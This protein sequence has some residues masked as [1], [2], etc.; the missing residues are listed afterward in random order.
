MGPSP[1]AASVGGLARSSKRPRFP[2]FLVTA[3]RTEE[4]AESDVQGLEILLG[5]YVQCSRENAGMPVFEKTNATPK[6]GFA[7]GAAPRPCFLYYWGAEDGEELEGWWFGEEVGGAEVLC[8][9]DKKNFPPPVTGWIVPGDPGQPIRCLRV[10]SLGADVESEASVAERTRPRPPSGPPPSGPPPSTSTS[11]SPPAQQSPREVVSSPLVQPLRPPMRVPRPRSALPPP[12]RV[13]G[14]HPLQPP[15]P[16]QQPPQPHPPGAVP[17][18]QQWPS[19]PVQQRPPQQRPP[20]LVQQPRPGLP[21][22]AVAPGAAWPRPV[23]AQPRSPSAGTAATSFAAPVAAFAS[24]FSAAETKATGGQGGFEVHQV[25]IFEEGPLG[26]RL[27]SG[28]PPVYVVEVKAGS[29]AARRGLKPGFEILSINGVPLTTVREVASGMEDLQRRPLRLLVRGPPATAFVLSGTGSYL[30][31]AAPAAPAPAT[32]PGRPMAAPPGPAAP[33]TP[34]A[35]LAAAAAA[36][37]QQRLVPPA[38]AA[39]PAAANPPAAK[40]KPQVVAFQPPVPLAKPPPGHQQPWRQRDGLAQPP[41]PPESAPQRVAVLAL[42]L[43]EDEAECWERLMGKVQEEKEQE[44]DR[45][46]WSKLRAVASML[47][48]QEAQRYY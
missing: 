17:L 25:E 10:S 19:Q 22:L 7:G 28:P 30:G 43:P 8:Y 37:Q 48:R 32:P 38:S 34:P 23:Q 21:Q 47:E 2:G 46:I 44:G 4:G 27:S 15:Q 31:A 45:P 33:N 3:V 14:Q 16:Q 24:P 42:S 41:P 35:A 6:G 39:W 18:A 5:Q 12:P 1:A 29:L 9:A 11:P 13:P 20:Q 26:I 40:P 36:R